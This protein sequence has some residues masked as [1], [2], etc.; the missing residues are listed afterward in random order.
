MGY[1]IKQR[2]TQFVIRKKNFEKV[3]E[4][5]NKLEPGGWVSSEAQTSKDIEEVFEAWRWN[6]YMDQKGNIVNIDFN[7]EKAGDDSKL[8]HAVAPYVEDGSFIEMS[9][10]EGEI[11]R[12]TF[13]DG[14]MIEEGC[15][16][17]WDNEQEI[18]AALLK[19]KELYPLLIGLH[20]SLD[21][22][23]EKESAK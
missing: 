15:E 14:E 1:Y 18:I 4:A 21:R 19:K 2:N 12:W 13:R 9:G 11:W 20:P 10:E 23:L 5:I 22:M 3:I 7:G 8:F 16:L 17:C 6:V